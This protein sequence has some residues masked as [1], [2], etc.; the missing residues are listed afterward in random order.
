MLNGPQ[1]VSAPSPEAPEP[2]D[3]PQ[4]VVEEQRPPAVAKREVTKP[5][6]TKV[7]SVLN[8]H[9]GYHRGAVTRS[10]LS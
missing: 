5:V 1:V 3:V 10:C 4:P 6:V 8:V 7:L 9:A 2:V